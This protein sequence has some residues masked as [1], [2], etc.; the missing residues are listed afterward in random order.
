MNVQRRIPKIALI[1]HSHVRNVSKS[2]ISWWLTTKNIFPIVAKYL[3][4]SVLLSFAKNFLRLSLIRATREAFDKIFISAFC[5]QSTEIPSV[6]RYASYSASRHAPFTCTI[7][8]LPLSPS[9]PFSRANGQADEDSGNTP[10][11]WRRLFWQTPSVRVSPLSILH[12]LSFQTNATGTKVSTHTVNCHHGKDN[13]KASLQLW[14][15]LYGQNKREKERWRENGRQGRHRRELN[16][17][18]PS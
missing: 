14:I 15:F 2:Y 11:I 13:V 6:R 4:I 7:Y 17:K 9:F 10:P 12:P 5:G 1:R 16:M 8:S 18:G 3:M